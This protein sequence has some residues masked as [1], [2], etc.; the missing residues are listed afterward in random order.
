MDWF[1]Q[2]RLADPAGEGFHEAEVGLDRR[3]AQ[4]PGTRFLQPVASDGFDMATAEGARVQLEVLRMPAQKIEQPDAEA[5]ALRHRLV[6]HALGLAAVLPVVPLQDQLQHIAAALG[7]QGYVVQGGL[8]VGAR[9]PTAFAVS[10]GGAVISTVALLVHG[11]FP[12][13]HSS[14]RWNPGVRASAGSGRRCQASVC[15]HR[16]SDGGAEVRK[17]DRQPACVGRNVAFAVANQVLKEP[18]ATPEA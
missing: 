7:V 16:Q 10:W 14:I 9:L 11:I 1:Q 6:A 17:S 18:E 5:R 13:F 15:R 12:F 4:P 2:L 3:R 8:F